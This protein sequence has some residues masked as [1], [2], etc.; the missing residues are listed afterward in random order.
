VLSEDSE[1]QPKSAS[2]AVPLDLGGLGLALCGRHEL[3]VM[4]LAG[5]LSDRGIDVRVLDGP[6][7]VLTDAAGRKIRILLLE[8]PL[9]AELRSALVSWP[10][11]IVLVDDAYPDQ[12][13][14]ALA[15]GAHA[16]LKKNDTLGELWRTLRAALRHRPEPVVPLTRRQ[17]EVLRLMADGLDNAQIALE[18]GI[19]QRTARAHVSSVLERLGVDNRTQAAVTA[20]RN[21]WIR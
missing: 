6:E 1:T 14:D 18:L 12:S 16:V 20:V 4:S 21:G 7:D 8:S 13:D 5:L 3:Y 19:S 17:R 10:V 11:V 2:P 9:P 15:L